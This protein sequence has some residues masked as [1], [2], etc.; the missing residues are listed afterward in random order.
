MTDHPEELKARAQ[1]VF[2]RVSACVPGGEDEPA[3]PAR[4]ARLDRGLRM[5]PRTTQ[6]IFRAKMIDRFSYAHIARAT[7]FSQRQVRRRMSH[8]LYH[9]RCLTDD[10][11][12][13]KWQ[14]RW[15]W[16]RRYWPF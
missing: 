16:W 9:L 1:R 8:A 13:S 3:D 4:L 11:D 15:W 5:L 14:I 2:E 6:Q 7:G 10:D 12:R